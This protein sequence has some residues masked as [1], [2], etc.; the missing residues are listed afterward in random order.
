MYKIAVLGSEGYVGKAFANMISSRYEVVRY[1]PSLGDKCAT[2]DEV[3]EAGLA[4]VCV[5]T[6]MSG[7]EFPHRCDTS[8]VE[9]VVSWLETPVILIKSTVEPGTT[10]RLKKKYNKRI[11]MSP[12]FIGEGK[13]FIPQEIDFSKRMEVTP[14]WVV[15]GDT[16]DVNYI[17]DLLVPILGPCKQYLKMT[18][19]DAE[20][21]KYFENYFLG[22]K[23]IFSNEM[24]EICDAFGADY[25]AVREGWLADPRVGRFHSINFKGREGFSGKCLPKDLNALYRAC[26]DKGYKPTLLR[27]VLETNNKIRKN[28]NLPI[29]YEV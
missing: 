4:V 7:D 13:Y 6:L 10:D 15:G 11:C 12:E 8:I 20:L 5:P 26:M 22:L 1:D 16:R 9:E 19:L 14:F 27:A 18:A 2:K 17:Y 3:N 28:H 23:V 24:R 29:D 21:N 25:Y